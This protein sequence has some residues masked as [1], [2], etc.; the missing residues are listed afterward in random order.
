MQL[1]LCSRIGFPEN[2]VAVN[3]R[4][5]VHL[6]R[7]TDR[8]KVS[9]SSEKL[10]NAVRLSLT[11]DVRHHPVKSSRADGNLEKIFREATQTQ[12]FKYKTQ[13]Q[14]PHEEKFTTVE[15]EAADALEM[16]AQAHEEGEAQAGERKISSFLVFLKQYLLTGNPLHRI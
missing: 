7:K 6:R 14:K 9:S 5:Y 8:G 16:A 11:G 15:E 1:F 3:M 10:T 2:V 12:T 13:I 4:G